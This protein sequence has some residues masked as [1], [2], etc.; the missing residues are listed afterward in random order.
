MRE[1]ISL[2]VVARSTGLEPVTSGVTGRHSNQLSYDR[3]LH[4][5][6]KAPQDK[7]AARE[8]AAGVGFEP[9]VD[10][11][12]RRFSKPVHSTALPPSRGGRAREAP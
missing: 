6:E 5:R 12:P 4:D 3:I 11:R 8:M 10:F 7:L 1:R 9:T 2:R